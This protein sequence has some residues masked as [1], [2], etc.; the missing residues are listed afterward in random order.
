M[1]KRE[2]LHLSQQQA[3]KLD[4]QSRQIAEQ[5]RRLDE[6]QK[7][8]RWLTE[9]ME[10]LLNRT[11]GRKSERFDPRQGQL[12]GSLALDPAS[13]VVKES[14]GNSRSKERR[15]GHGRRPFPQHLPRDVQRFTLPKDEQICPDCGTAMKEMGAEICERGHIVRPKILVRRLERVKYGCPK[16]HAVKVAQGPSPLIE[17]CKYEPSVYAHITVAKYCDHQ[18]LHRLSSIFKRY[19]M[20]LPKSTMWDMIVRVQELVA[21]P[22]LAQ[23]S[24]ELLEERILQADETPVPVVVEHLEKGKRVKKSQKGYLWIWRRKHKVVLRFE[25][26]RSRDGPKKFLGDWK[27]TCVSDGFPVY[28]SLRQTN[29]IICA[30]CWA[31]SRRKFKEALD[32]GTIQATL[33]IRLIRRLFRIERWVEHLCKRNSLT[34]DDSL[35]FRATA[36][37]RVSRNV[38]QRIEQETTRLRESPDTLPQSKLGKALHYLENQWQPLTEFLQDP[39]LPIENNASERGLRHAVLGRKNWQCFASPRGGEVAADLYSL[40][41]SAKAVGADP[42]AYL[43]DLLQLVE[44]TPFSKIAHLTPWAWVERNPEHRIETP[45]V[46]R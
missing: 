23:M 5:S 6:L 16:G 28:G 1:N 21:R 26:S 43:E 18:P 37:D 25:L 27:G 46:D 15:P 11:Y 7:Q 14:K 8:N 45:F 3:T 19:G 10:T 38:I 12:F 17:R 2:L 44:T 30:G 42:E 32:R 35:A 39:E 22:I 20:E 33:T 4:E 31:H 34:E 36:R 29:E 41:Y 9:Q 40:L 13:E 24:K